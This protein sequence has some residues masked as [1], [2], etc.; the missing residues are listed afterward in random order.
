MSNLAA[1]FPFFA[2]IADRVI[3]AGPWIFLTRMPG[4]LA[5]FLLNNDIIPD[6]L[7]QDLGMSGESPRG[8]SGQ[9]RPMGGLGHAGRNKSCA[10]SIG[11]SGNWGDG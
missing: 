1:S 5:F 4:N 7:S 8:K 11:L 9:L 3:P 6:S 2:T 10:G